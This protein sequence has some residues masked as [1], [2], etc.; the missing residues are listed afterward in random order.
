MWAMTFPYEKIVPPKHNGDNIIFYDCY[1]KLK[2]ITV[3]KSA[4]MACAETG[5]TR[6]YYF[7][8]SIWK[9]MTPRN[10]TI[11]DTPTSFFIIIK[12]H[13]AVVIRSKI[14]QFL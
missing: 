10:H 14:T 3:I 1:L 7:I 9:P 2:I 13:P 11:M 6:P 4:V 5:K 12:N 8:G